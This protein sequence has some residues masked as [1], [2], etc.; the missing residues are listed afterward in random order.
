MLFPS[1]LNKKRRIPVRFPV[2]APPQHK[3]YA[4]WPTFVGMGYGLEEPHNLGKVW[5]WRE[6][7]YESVRCH[8]YSCELELKLDYGFSDVCITFKPV[9]LTRGDK[10]IAL[11][12]GNRTWWD[13]KDP[14]DRLDR[15]CTCC[16]QHGHHSCNC[17]WCFWL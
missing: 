15:E 17:F 4:W 7:Y 16:P 10:R 1:S 9:H 5:V 11:A 13:I 14:F 2:N 8:T 12:E 3:R 6:F